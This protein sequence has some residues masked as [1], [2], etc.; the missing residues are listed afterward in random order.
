MDPV[1]YRYGADAQSYGLA[2]SMFHKVGVVRISVFGKSLRNREA[3]VGGMWEGTR[4]G[5]VG[6]WCRTDAS[7]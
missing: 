6:F 7:H 2:T 4:E 1:P 3:A 5:H